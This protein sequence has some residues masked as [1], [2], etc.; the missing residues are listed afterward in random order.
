LDLF[1]GHGDSFH[2]C[3]VVTWEHA[4]SANE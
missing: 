4:L 3:P 2:T 1:E